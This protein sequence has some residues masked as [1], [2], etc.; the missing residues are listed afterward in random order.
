MKGILA[1]TKS[2][3]VWVNKFLRPYL[4]AYWLSILLIL[5]FVL[6][7]HFFNFW[8]GIFPGHHIIRRTVVT[9]ALGLFLF[10]APALFNFRLKYLI[11]SAI[12]FFVSLIFIVQFLYYSYS[13]G[14]LQASAL[15]YL[16]QGATLFGTVKILL[17]YRLLFFAVGPLAVLA[18]LIF[19]CRGYMV[20]KVVLKK[21]KLIAGGF[22]ILFTIL[23]YGYLFFREYTEAGNVTHIYAYNKLYDVNALVSK[24][25]V[26]NFSFGDV[27]AFGLRVDEVTASDAGLVE[28]WIKQRPATAINKNNF[29]IAQKRN[30]ILIQVESLENAVIGKQVAGQEITPYLNKL[31][32]AGLYFSNFYAPIGPGTTADTEFSVLN[33]LYPL[34]NTVAFIDYAY[35]H[36]LAL[37]SLLK[38]NGYHTYALHGD[39]ASFW[40]RANIYPQLG[41]EHWLSRQD[42]V[43]PRE[44]GVYGLGD[45]D[46]FNQSISKLQSFPQPF[47][48]TLITLT[49]HTPFNLP[50]DL[51]SLNSAEVNNLDWLQ[52]QY[53][54]SINYVDKAIGEFIA[55]LKTA[56]LYDNSLIFIYGDHTSFTNISKALEVNDAVFGD[57]Q[58][59]KV[60]LIILAPGVDLKGINS[61]P[62]SQVDIYPTAANLLGAEIPVT[63]FGRDLMADTDGLVIHRNLV[64]GTVKS[65]LTDNLAY[66]SSG[67][68]IFEKGNCL[69]V[70]DKKVLAVENCRALYDQAVQAVMVSDLMI[71]GDIIITH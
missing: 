67:D 52:K 54:Q 47:M 30:L 15:L 14:F 60:P 58:Y 8:L 53:L 7:N 19:S 31:V 36:Y 65:V 5:I 28:A 44:I 2:F 10:G 48:A 39:V 40:N 68:G 20:E 21:E 51:V 3:F 71:K 17:D 59:T 9:I 43:T 37:P 27:L 41:Y 6:Q 64:S 55:N 16:G 25:G 18:T 56:G 50:A 61:K 26:I 23:G 1:S 4:S 42:F 29:G 24:L 33:S 49:S 66:H 57:L 22:I 62:A 69:D 45:Q 11:L 35:N 32:E 34:P 12:S 70:F 13:G 63:I 46:F 38:N